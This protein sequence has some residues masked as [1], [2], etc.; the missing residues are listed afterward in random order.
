MKIYAHN[1]LNEILRL[2]RMIQTVSLIRGQKN[3]RSVWVAWIQRY[4]RISCGSEMMTK[5]DYIK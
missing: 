2:A 1:K 5:T 4:T 3:E